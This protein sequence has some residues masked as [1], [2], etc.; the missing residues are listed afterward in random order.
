MA[1]WSRS[2]D[3]GGAGSEE[4]NHL[5]Q[6]IL[7]ESNAREA[8]KPPER[9]LQPGLAALQKIGAKEQAD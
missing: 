1:E 2:S 3:G 6:E 4:A 5:L 8:R 9:R 7:A